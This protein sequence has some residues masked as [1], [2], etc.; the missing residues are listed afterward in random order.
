MGVNLPFSESF[1]R[2][3]FAA[4]A[5][6]SVVFIVLGF[7][8]CGRDWDMLGLSLGVTL[9]PAAIGALV[10]LVM[11]IPKVA[12]ADK[13]ALAKVADDQGD[14]GLPLV[15]L[16][17]NTNLAQIS[18]WLTTILVGLSLINANKILD[19]IGQL[20]TWYGTMFET[21][22]PNATAESAYGL[23]LTLSAFA[24][25]GMLMYMW[26]QTRLV[27]AL[28]QTYKAGQGNK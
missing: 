16:I 18:D 14:A 27:D 22:L 7:A 21:N 11:G 13:E 24:I 23:S 4:A 2:G 12:D 25:A 5:V 28:R 3:L 17:Y 26:T 6:W 8:V 1:A 10:G 19:G 20:G 15:R 9:A